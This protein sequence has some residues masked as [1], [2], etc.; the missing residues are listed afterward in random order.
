MDQITDTKHT[1]ILLDGDNL[2]HEKSAVWDSLVTK[3][4]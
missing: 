3:S 4:L 1:E 2:Q